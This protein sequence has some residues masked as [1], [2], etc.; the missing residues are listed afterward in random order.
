MIR[1]LFFWDESMKAELR[2]CRLSSF[3]LQIAEIANIISSFMINQQN[4]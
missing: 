3:L 2:E 1:T 4:L